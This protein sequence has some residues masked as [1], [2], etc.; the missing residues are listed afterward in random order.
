[1][2]ELLRKPA[3]QD[4]KTPPAPRHSSPAPAPAIAIAIATAPATAPEPLYRRPGHPTAIQPPEYR[5]YP[6]PSALGL[7]A[8]YLRDTI[9]S[10]N[11]RVD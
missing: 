8:L 7:D 1:M 3:P 9:S 6:T 11:Y 10:L 4:I 2:P 5:T